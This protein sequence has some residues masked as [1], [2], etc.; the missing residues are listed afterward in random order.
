MNKPQIGID[1]VLTKRE[2][3]AI[4]TYLSTTEVIKFSMIN[5]FCQDAALSITKHTTPHANVLFLTEKFPLLTQINCRLSNLPVKTQLPTYV[6]L[7]ILCDSNV[8]KSTLEFHA[9]CVEELSAKDSDLYI[10]FPSFPHLTSL[11]VRYTQKFS[12]FLPQ[13]IQALPKL[14]KLS[15]SSI[16]TD[17]FT[18]ITSLTTFTDLKDVK[19]DFLELKRTTLSNFM[20]A[21]NNMPNIDFVVTIH[22]NTFQTLGYDQIDSVLDSNINTTVFFHNVDLRDVSAK[23]TWEYIM[24]KVYGDPLKF[25]LVFTPTKFPWFNQEMMNFFLSKYL[26][27]YPQ[28]TVTRR[29]E[30][31][32]E[33]LELYDKVEFTRPPKD[34]SLC[35]GLSDVLIEVGYGEKTRR[36]RFELDMSRCPSVTKLAVESLEIPRFVLGPNLK[37]LEIRKSLF[38][39]GDLTN[40]G[41]TKLILKEDNFDDL[42]ISEHLCSLEV[43]QCTSKGNGVL[44]GK[45]TTLSE[46]L[47]DGFS[48]N[49]SSSIPLNSI[50]VT[51]KNISGNYEMLDFSKS[52]KLRFLKI[53]NMTGLG[54]L[55]IPSSLVSLDLFQVGVSQVDTSQILKLTNVLLGDCSKLETMILSSSVSTLELKKCYIKHFSVMNGE[56]MY[57][58]VSKIKVSEM[59]VCPT[60]GAFPN[61]KEIE[62]SES[63]VDNTIVFPQKLKKFTGTNCIMQSLNYA[64]CTELSEICT[65]DVYAKETNFPNSLEDLHL[66]YLS[67]LVPELKSLNHLTKLTNVSISCVRCSELDLSYSTNLQK[68]EVLGV[69]FTT[70][71]LPVSLKEMSLKFILNPLTLFDFNNLT[72]LTSLEIRTCSPKVLTLPTS[73]NSLSINCSPQVVVE[74]SMIEPLSLLTQLILIDVTLPTPIIVDD[75]PMINNL[76][77]TILIRKSGSSV[78]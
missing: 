77:T 53:E 35:N 21:L 62:M 17:M 66:T 39:I 3:N 70:T 20:D 10:P 60:F 40:D 16:T 68:L 7:E 22:M 38:L 58:Q 72:L 52:E 48:S 47:F 73:L 42:L 1:R 32:V 76:S 19:I 51:L 34:I 54:T 49:I 8:L 65:F 2:H 14:K 12:E 57:N 13:T 67:S 28:M 30:E 5:H 74:K 25:F 15:L 26:P 55:I 24:A 59:A 71:K 43:H 78:Y 23:D 63:I 11:C 64:A 61:L 37:E 4:L 56:M 44:L 9:E 18:S 50:S 36:E 45:C 31:R 46:I 29:L 41:L 6:R 75:F 69:N 27:D 33:A